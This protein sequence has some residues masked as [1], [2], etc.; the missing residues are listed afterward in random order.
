MGLIMAGSMYS[1]LTTS[2]FRLPSNLGPMTVYYPPLVEIVD[3]QGDPVLDL[4]ENPMYH[5][6]PDIP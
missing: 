6:P 5:D 2:Q 4:A 3:A 1:L